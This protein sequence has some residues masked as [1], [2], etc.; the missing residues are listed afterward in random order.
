MATASLLLTLFWPQ[1]RELRQGTPA[2]L[3]LPLRI[4]AP[5]DLARPAALLQ[6]ELRQRLGERAVGDGGRTVL[7]LRLDP[8]T[9]PRPEGYGLTTSAD[10]V[11]LS[12]HDEQGAFWAVHSFLQLLAAARPRPDGWT[13][14]GIA[15]RDW[16]EC[17][18]RAFMMQGAWTRDVDFLKQNLD[19]LARFKV[20]YVAI[21]F[22]P[23]VVLDALPDAARGARFTKAQA[24]EV[25][26]YARSLG[27]RPIGYLNL[28]GHLDRAYQQAPYTDHGGVMVGEDETYEKFVY[29]ILTEMLDAYGPIEYFHCGMDE[30]W[31]LFRWASETG[32]NTPDLLVR[33]LQRVDAFLRQRGAKLVIWHDMLMAPELEKEL[34]AP[35]GPANGGPP[36]NTAAA[37]A[38]VPKDIILDYWFYDPLEQYPGLDWLQAQGFTV[39]ASPWQTPFSL[40]RYAQQRGVPRMGTHWAGPPACFYSST[41]SQVP[42]VYAQAAWSPSA[43]D[44]GPHP[45]PGLTAAAR[46]A[47]DRE[48]WRRPSLA[49]QGNTVLLL[50]TTAEPQRLVWPADAARAPEVHGGL[51]FDFGHPAEVTPL[52]SSARV[53]SDPARA[54]TIV[55]TGGDRLK[56]DGVNTGR[57]PDQLVLYAPPRASTGTNIYGVEV[58]VSAQGQVLEASTYGSGNH[59]IPAGG[60]VLSAHVGPHATA[61]KRLEALRPGD[62]VAALDAQGDW[63]GGWD[64][65][66]YELVLPGASCRVDA[67]DRD[68][69]SG[70]LVVYRPGQGTGRTGTNQWGIE[71]IVSAGKVA[72]VEEGKGNAAIPLDGLVASAHG[73]WPAVEAL[74]RLRPG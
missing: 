61:A 32:Q 42:A 15:L 66:R 40:A 1:P 8:A 24:K 36:Q 14:P 48:L 22:G 17:P 33:H 35:V 46:R 12:A 73:A 59:A 55:L 74:R 64:P 43:G 18:F 62:R 49:V 52:P 27:L 7:T 37:I 44:P 41:Y 71:A 54:A 3:A 70:L 25:V 39:W 63:L 11:L 56:L 10:G 50:R 16:P 2:G 38:K 28:L 65:G 20:G 45:E 5:A 51:P 57:G 23:Q 69:E 4:E 68:R 72:A 31:D 6:H 34:H 13:L 26:A 19:L 67:V 29:P 60:F 47:T 9:H 58:A 30:A 53:L 21:E